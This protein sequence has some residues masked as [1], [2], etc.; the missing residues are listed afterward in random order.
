[1]TSLVYGI[2][3]FEEKQEEE[4]EKKEEDKKT[5]NKVGSGTIDL[6]I[7]DLSVKS[8]IYDND[9]LTKDT[10]FLKQIGIP[11]S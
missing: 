9:P 8:I 10:E 3:I 11:M 1:M 7:N 2:I 6:D 4:Q 5:L